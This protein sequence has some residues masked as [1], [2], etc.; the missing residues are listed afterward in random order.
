M[1]KTYRHQNDWG[2]RPKFKRST[3]KKKNTFSEAEDEGS[4]TTPSHPHDPLNEVWEK[5][6]EYESDKP[7]K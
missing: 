3:R 6:G 7:N 2:K 5:V 4:D 1:G